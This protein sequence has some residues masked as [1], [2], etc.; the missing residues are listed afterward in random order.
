[1]LNQRLDSDYRWRSAERRRSSVMQSAQKLRELRNDYEAVTLLA[2]AGDLRGR[3]YMRLAEIDSVL[4][5][6][7]EARRNLE[8]SLQTGLAPENQRIGL[9]MLGDLLERHLGQKDEA[10][11]VYQQIM[12][13]Y[14][15]TRE[16]ELSKLRLQVLNHD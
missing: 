8:Q 16:A 13:E 3:A 9:L 15:G 5:D 14:P 1:M 10:L 12:R 4:G 11:M 6:Y 7:E 2:R